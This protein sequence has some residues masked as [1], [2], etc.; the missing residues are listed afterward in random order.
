MDSKSALEGIVGGAKLFSETPRSQPTWRVM[1][2]VMLHFEGKTF[3][4]P[5]ERASAR[6]AYR[7]KR[8]GRSDGDSLL[9]E[10]LPY[11]HRNIGSWL[12]PERFADRDKYVAEMLPQRLTLLDGVLAGGPRR[13]I[14]CYGQGDWAKFKG[15][16]PGAAWEIVN[17]GRKYECANW[18]GTKVTLTYHF[19][20]WFNEDERLDELSAVALP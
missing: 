8:L 9:T 15:L 18:N 10:L 13:A 20:R 5:E 16:F 7:A 12:Y 11:P 4:S 6:K 2:D 17:R 14:I 1:A 3:G 19:S